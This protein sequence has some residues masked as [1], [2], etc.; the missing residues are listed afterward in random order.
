MYDFYNSYCQF[1]MISAS[2]PSFSVKIIKILRLILKSYKAA[3]KS[4]VILHYF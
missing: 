4:F 1:L 2:K 3:L